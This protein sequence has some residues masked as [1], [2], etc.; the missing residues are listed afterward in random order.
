VRLSRRPVC[1][2]TLLAFSAL[3]AVNV[4]KAAPAVHGET[5]RVLQATDDAYAEGGAARR[6]TS[7]SQE[8]VA[9]DTTYSTRTSHVTFDVPATPP[10][11]VLVGAQLVAR[12]RRSSTEVGLRTVGS[13]A[14]SER[15][16]D[17][18]TRP[19][20]SPVQDVVPVAAAGTASLDVTDQVGA[21][22]A[23]SSALTSTQGA[24]A[25]D[26]TGSPSGGPRLYLNHPAPSSHPVTVPGGR[27][28]FGMSVAP[29]PGESP[30]AAVARLRGQFGGLPVVRVFTPGLLPASWNDEPTLRALGGDSAVV[31]SFK[32]DPRQ[33]IAGTYDDRVRSFLAGR[34]AGISTYVAYYHEPEDDIET[35]VLSAA[36]FRAATEHLAP[37]IRDSGAMPT[38]ILMQYT[39]SAASHRDW[40]DYYSPA[41]DVLA[42]DAYNTSARDRVPSYR[43]VA[44]LVAPVLAVAAET[45]KAFG[46]AELG[47]PCIATDPTCAGRAA[48]LAGLA[49][50]FAASGAHFATYWNRPDVGAGF[51]YSLSDAASVSAWK[52]SMR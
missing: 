43:P 29:L 42:W 52:G 3:G 33:V 2:A 46:W 21:G 12:T 32:A 31:Y 38:T 24:S 20:V 13:H 15:T 30:A 49:A 19:A 36:D 10:G 37:I 26:P 45:G 34:P 14:W 51:D 17:D 39:L 28:R 9:A 1:V 5:A 44:G 47:S 41:V 35:G 40:H 4:A 8:L 27:T 18:T 22:R 11:K 50:G 7:D 48:W 23:P 25:P 16:R 6:T